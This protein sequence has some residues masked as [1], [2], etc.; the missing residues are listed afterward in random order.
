MSNKND[1]AVTIIALIISLAIVGGVGWWL[2]GNSNFLKLNQTATQTTKTEM[3]A[4]SSQTNCQTDAAAV[5]SLAVSSDYQT[6]AIAR[7]EGQIEIWDWQNQQEKNAP[8]QGHKGR[9]NDIAMSRNG[10]I[11]VSGGGDG[12][13][14]VW[15]LQT[16]NLRQKLLSRQ[17]G[18]I[19]SVDIRSDGTKVAAGSSTGKIAVWNLS[20]SNSNSPPIQLQIDSQKTKIQTVAFHP[21]N[22]NI[23]ATGGNDGKIWI[24]NLDTQQ[25]TNLSPL[26][27]SNVT[28]VFDLAFSSDGTQLASGTNLGEI[29]IWNLNTGERNTLKFNAHDFLVSAV[30]FGNNQ[31]YLATASYDETVKLWNFNPSQSEQRVNSLRGHYGFVYDVAFLTPTGETLASAGYDG[32][33]RIWQKNDQQQWQ[34]EILC[35]AKNT[36]GNETP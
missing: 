36:G 30:R 19:L 25:Q 3:P 11:L 13:V 15:D 4:T 34:N 23:L 26:E 24:W 7:S 29:D 31:Q 21:T 1:T 33:L 9:I 28:H 14:K 17:F 16:G 35:S 27:K 22:P 6:L 12:T 10:K 2:V 5:L 20:D 18:R 8:L 32:T